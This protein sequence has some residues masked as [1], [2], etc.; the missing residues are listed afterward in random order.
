M[1]EMPDRPQ[2]PTNAELLN[3]TLAAIRSLGGS[4][5]I[6][7]IGN[8]VTADLG[9]PEDVTQVPHGKGSQTE[10]A[11]RLGWARTYL[12]SFGIL[13]NSARGVWSFT[14]QGE[15]TEAVDPREVIQAY[16]NLYRERKQSGAAAGLTAPGDPGD[17]DFDDPSPEVG[18]WRETLMASIQNMDPYAFERLCQRLLRES[19]FV[20]VEVTGRPGDGGID[21]RGVFRMAD[22]ISFSV[23]FQCKQWSSSVG[24]NVVRELRGALDN[25]AERGLILTTGTFTRGAEHEA[26][27]PGAIPIDL[28]DGELLLD[29]LKELGLGVSTRMVEDVEVDTAWFSAI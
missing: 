23:K 11:Y 24:P 20:E 6:A 10:L 29:K 27:R 28:I 3:P 18:S 14:P 26:T 25:S 16:A 22:L 21:G 2:I 19:G 7:E 17:E 13:D 1:A 5:T 12:K 15:N 9:L 4:A 8:R